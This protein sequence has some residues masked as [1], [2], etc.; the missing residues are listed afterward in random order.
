MANA[1]LPEQE[2]ILRSQK[3]DLNCFNRLVET[4]QGMVYNVALRMLGN[5]QAA[6]DAT[7]NS[8]LHAFRSIRQFRGGSFRAWLFRIV[9]NACRD[10]MRAYQRHPA[11]SLD[12][13]LLN[14]AKEGLP[15]GDESPEDHALRQEL[16][17]VIAAGIASLSEDQR[18]VVILSDIEG[19]SYE[20]IAAA[21]SCSVGTV[22]SRLNRG[23]TRLRDYL[24]SHRELLPKDFRLYK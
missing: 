3:G 7:Q 23:R 4:Y 6:E 14:P 5:V 9:T 8:F 10:E 19:L 11:S 1:G 24:M 20:E 21:T 13:M 12:A 16:G 2:L 18:W 15:N 22:K 17:R